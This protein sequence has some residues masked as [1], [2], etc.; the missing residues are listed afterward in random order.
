MSRRS[1]LAVGIATLAL[2][3]PRAAHAQDAGAI[4][5]GHQ[6]L[7]ASRCDDAE[8]L[9]RRALEGGE[10]ARARAELGLALACRSA[11]VEAER[12]LE[13]ALARPDPWVAANRAVLE[14]NLAR[15]RTRLANL[16]VEVDGTRA[17]TVRVDGSPRG[18]AGESLRVVAGTVVIEVVAEGYEPVRRRLDI[19][20][21]TRARE[22]FTLVGA[23]RG[24]AP[25]RGS[26]WPVVGWTTAGLAGAAAIGG[27]VA[28]V[29]RE[30]A[31][32]TYNDD[33]RCDRDPAVPRSQECPDQVERWQSAETWMLVSFTAAGVLAAASVAALIL[34]ASDG[35]DD[36]AERARVRCAPALDRP[37]V[38]CGGVF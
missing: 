33:A 31:I 6:A 35:G 16:V 5:R 32:A 4:E 22:R 9:F 29:V 2:L 14:G 37:G 18:P 8:A 34:S 10:S 23:R 15:A 26:G 1:P 36:E 28:T 19:A 30:D 20:P 17:A 12:N 27:V 11:W 13:A 21:G 3:G 7:I 25:A 24:G 38:I